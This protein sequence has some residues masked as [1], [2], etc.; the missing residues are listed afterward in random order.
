V[1]RQQSRSF[2]VVAELLGEPPQ[3]YLLLEG[4]ARPLLMD[5]SGL[6]AVV[7]ALLVPEAWQARMWCEAV[8]E[9]SLAHASHDASQ[10]AGAG[11]D[12][13]GPPMPPKVLRRCA[14]AEV[15]RA[16]GEAEDVLDGAQ[17]MLIAQ[18]NDHTR[19]LERLA[20][21][22]ERRE[23]AQKRTLEKLQMAYDGL[24]AR[25]ARQDKELAQLASARERL[26]AGPESALGA[27]PAVLP[28]CERDA[29][30]AALARWF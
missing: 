19:E 10:A 1:P 11:Q 13:D 16:L 24:R 20:R 28:A 3:A 8:Q 30:A 18:R 9:P 27:P 12:S 14:A 25:A 2:L 17:H 22:A 23:R 5:E 7:D 4:V 29:L 6:G 21:N 26:R 15:S